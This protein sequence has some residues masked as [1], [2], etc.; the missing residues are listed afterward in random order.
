MGFAKSPHR[1]RFPSPVV[2]RTVR[3]SS[4]REQRRS[5]SERSAPA[6]T[7]E[8]IRPRSTEDSHGSAPVDDCLRAASD[9]RFGEALPREPGPRA[10][11]SG[12][13][14]VPRY[15]F[16]TPVP[17]PLPDSGRWALGPAGR[18][19]TPLGVSTVEPPPRVWTVTAEGSDGI[20]SADRP[21]TV[22]TAGDRSSATV[23]RTAGPAERPDGCRPQ[24][25]HRGSPEGA[26]AFTGGSFLG[27]FSRLGA[28]GAVLETLSTPALQCLGRRCPPRWRRAGRRTPAGRPP[29]AGRDARR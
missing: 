20:P 28:C 21:T 13:R 23:G 22:G 3:W 25:R 16:G 1:I 14:P 24:G 8:A 26:D 11:R 17:A 9:G 18:R 4:R 5:G 10:L 19:E 12:E 6:P 15:R 2:S 29:P 7:I 27:A